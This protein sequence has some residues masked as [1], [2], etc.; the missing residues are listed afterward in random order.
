MGNLKGQGLDE[1]FSDDDLT[2]MICY[3]PDS[4]PRE[5]NKE[6]VLAERRKMKKFL[7]VSVTVP[8]PRMQEVF[9]L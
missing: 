8:S 4:A 2:D 7:Q 3:G 9:T 1:C 6:K 5:D